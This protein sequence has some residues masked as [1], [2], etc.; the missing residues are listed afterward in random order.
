LKG[1]RNTSR[2]REVVMSDKPRE[3]ST[4]ERILKLEIQVEMLQRQ[5]DEIYSVILGKEGGS[6]E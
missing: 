3:R 5:I 6:D 2:Q 4:E 1:S